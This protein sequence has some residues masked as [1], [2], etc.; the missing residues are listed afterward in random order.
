MEEQ[1]NKFELL[2]IHLAPCY[3][4]IYEYN[5]NGG[6]IGYDIQEWTDELRVAV[7][8][9][10]LHDLPADVGNHLLDTDDAGPRTAT[11][12]EARV[13]RLLELEPW[14]VALEVRN[15]AVAAVPTLHQLI[16]HLDEWPSEDERCDAETWLR[17]HGKGVSWTEVVCSS[18]RFD[19][20]PDQVAQRNNRHPEPYDLVHTLTPSELLNSWEVVVGPAE[21]DLTDD[22]WRLMLPHF[23]LRRNPNG[24]FS[25]PQSELDAKR[26]LL[27]GIRFKMA[28]GV[29]WPQVPARYGYVYSIYQS[30]RYNQRSGM[31]ARLYEGL[32]T[33]D[34]ASRV[35]EWL[36][37]V[38]DSDSDETSTSMEASTSVS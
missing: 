22:E 19:L 26:R 32:R 33:S 4:N 1:C 16:G 25:R 34:Q 31:F 15:A 36:E 2:A 37:D 30:Y 6:D 27:N 5:M 18:G 8:E 3:G 7:G 13:D 35:V 14:E 38:L 12:K 17:T 29:H 11:N 23:G 21:S 20:L 9:Y 10:L 24:T 28:H